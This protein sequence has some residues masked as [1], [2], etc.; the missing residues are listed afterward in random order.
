MDFGELEYL[1]AVERQ[2]DLNPI[3]KSRLDELKRSNPNIGGVNGGIPQFQFD[4]AG[5][6]Q[7]PMEN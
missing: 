6:Q 2:G 1:L 3:Q 5:K 4:Y 7:K